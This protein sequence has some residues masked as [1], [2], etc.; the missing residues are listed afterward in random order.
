MH[1]SYKTPLRNIFLASRI[2][3]VTDQLVLV[4]SN[5]VTKVKETNVRL[6]N[7]LRF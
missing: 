4:S 7:P 1:W 2:T 5:F 3:Y 6:F